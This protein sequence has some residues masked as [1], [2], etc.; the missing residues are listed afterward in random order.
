MVD[1]QNGLQE[2][3]CLGKW[4]DREVQSRFLQACPIEVVE[5]RIRGCWRLAVLVMKKQVAELLKLDL[6][7]K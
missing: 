2:E 4:L 7:Y 3:Y 5:V 1:Q 6:G